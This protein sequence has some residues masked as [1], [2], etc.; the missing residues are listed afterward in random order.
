M[1]IS[2]LQRSYMRVPAARVV[3]DDDARR[4]ILARIDDC[5]TTGMLAQGK[6]VREFE[7]RWA[8]YTGAKYAIAVNTGSSAIEICLRIIGVEG[9]KVLVPVN[10]FAATA[11]SVLLAG[12]RVKFVDIDPTTLSLSLRELESRLTPQTTGAII[13]HIGGVI[14]PEIEEIASWCRDR[15]LW[16]FEDCAHAHGSENNGRRA[17][18]FGIAGAY[19]FFATKVMTSGEGGMIVTSDEVIAQRAVRLRDHGKPEPWVSYHTDLGTNWRMSELNAAVALSQLAR[20]DDF[21]AWR[22]RIARLYT[23]LLRDVP[24][25]TPISP[26]AGTSWYKYILL[27]DAKIDRDKLKQSMAEQ[28]VSLSGEVYSTPLHKQPIFKDMSH[29]SFPVAE[30]FCRRHICLPLYYG[31][32]QEEAEFV[33]DILKR[34]L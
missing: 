21:I 19:S 13:V 7:Q 23:E 22:D 10:T 26:N 34:N 3:F 28:G 8:E 15:G 6:Y 20:L 1:G 18:S 16:L 24:Q 11:T 17:G 12:G 2:E 5:L 14:T 33:V 31:M 4:E 27:L 30:D 25:V 29:E 9:K 32:S